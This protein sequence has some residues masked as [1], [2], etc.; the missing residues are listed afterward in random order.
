VRNLHP[1][2]LVGLTATPDRETPDDQIIFRYPL[3]AAIADKLVK[4]PVIVGRKDDRTDPFTKLSDGAALLQAKAEA[5]AGHTEP[6]QLPPVN[7]MMLLVA[8]DTAEPDEYGS[9]LTS[10]EFYGGQHTDAVLVV[11]S[12]APDDALAALADTDGAERLRSL[13]SSDRTSS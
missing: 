7:P 1:S 12:K 4:T 10:E 13:I 5:L 8:S 3:A 6:R 2:A 11:H 9:I